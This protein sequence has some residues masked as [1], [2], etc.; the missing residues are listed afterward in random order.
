M[1]LRFFPSRGTY[2]RKGIVRGGASWPQHRAVRPGAGL[3]PLVVSLAPSPPPSHLRSSRIFGKNRRF[4]FCFI[5]FWEYF[6]CNFSETQKQQKTG[7]WH[8]CI[9]LIGYFWKMH[10]NSMKCNKTQSK[11]CINKHGISKIIDTFE[12]YQPPFRLYIPLDGKN[13]KAR[14]IF[15]ET[16]CRPP[17][18]STRDRE[19]P[20]ALPGTLSERGITARGLLRHHGCLQSD[21][22][23]VYLRLRVHNSS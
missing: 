22:W 2:R 18:S 1:S 9:L 10:K 5:Q 8:C 12:T 19:G 23:V 15:H 16:Y 21:A 17:P 7:N 4:G 3:R 20:E 11:W 6:L 14:S 13:L